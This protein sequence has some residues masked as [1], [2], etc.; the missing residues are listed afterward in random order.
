M[1][2][3]K[4]EAGPGGVGRLKEFEVEVEGMGRFE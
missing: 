4:F 1:S 2:H 3:Y